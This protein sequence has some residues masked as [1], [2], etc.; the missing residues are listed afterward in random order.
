MNNGQYEFYEQANEALMQ[1]FATLQ[2]PVKLCTKFHQRF[3]NSVES[4]EH[5]VI[6]VRLLCPKA[7]TI[8]NPSDFKDMAKQ[9]FIFRACNAVILERLIVQRSANLR[10]AI[11]CD[12]LLKVANRTERDLTYSSTKHVFA[13][14]ASSPSGMQTKFRKRNYSNRQYINKIQNP[15]YL[16][17]GSQGQCYNYSANYS[18]LNY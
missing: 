9:Q 11:E 7:Y 17:L 1:Y 5:L 8:L 14:G 18:R 6:D 2:T 3:K 4:L 13:V 16:A 10:V 12:R 15:N